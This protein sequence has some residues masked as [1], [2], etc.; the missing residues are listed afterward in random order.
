MDPA[1][2]LEEEHAV[3]RS[4]LLSGSTGADRLARYLDLEERVLFDFYARHVGD[5][6]AL[7]RAR[8]EQAS[9]ADL[10]QGDDVAPDELR[11]RFDRHADL[12]VRQ[13]VPSLDERLDRTQ[14]DDLGDALE[15]ARQS[16]DEHDQPPHVRVGEADAARHEQGGT[17]SP[18]ASLVGDGGGEQ[19]DAIAEP[20]EP[21]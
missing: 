18:G 14:R 7:A 16:W 3:L 8:D 19:G 13:L 5:D 4:A 15:E 6:D 21:A 17:A 1:A 20:N 10:V 12:V 11:A 2:V 9:L